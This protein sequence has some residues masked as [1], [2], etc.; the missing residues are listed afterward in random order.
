MNNIPRPN[1]KTAS[2]RLKLLLLPLLFLAGLVV[3]Q[4]ANLY[5]GRQV[6]EK[7]VFPGFSEQAMGSYRVLLKATVDIEVATVAARIKSLKT[8]E[9]KIAAIVEETDLSRFFDDGSGYFFAYDLAGVRINVPVNKSGNGKNFMHLTDPNGVRFIEELIKA[10]GAGGGFVDYVFEKP[11]KG[12]QPKLA[13]AALIPGTEFVIGTGVYIDNVEAELGRLREKVEQRSRHY[14]KLTAGLFAAVLLVT[15]AVSVWVSE[16]T[17]RAIRAI[18]VE[19][20]SGSEQITAAAGLVSSASQAL[21]QGTSEQAASLEETSS[22]LEEM[23]SMTR[24]NSES[25]KQANELARGARQSADAGVEDMQAMGKAMAD[26][27][28]SGDDI[29]KIIKTIDEIAFQTNILALNAAVEAARAGEAG[30][31]FAVVADEV[32]ALAQR[33]A[34]ASRETADKIEG[35]I[36]KTAQGVQISNRVGSRLEEIVEKVRRVDA[37]V[38]EVAAASGEQNEGVQQINAAT[39]RM[40]KV[41]QAN[42]AGA[43]ESAAAAEELSSQAISLN[44]VIATLRQLVSGTER[45]K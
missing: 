7:V 21:A 42:A 43:E 38:A 26:I 14:I 19:L 31:G 35:A 29:A 17:G 40:D 13:Y 34:V 4:L 24:R 44:G 6:S 27:K 1:R 12:V 23:S 25:A 22:L 3:L 30:A 11:G 41:V 37:L 28:T 45:S 33:S 9:E 16:S 32:R 39:G 10:G 18:I 36:V 20:S 15:V 5:T 8:R 2:L